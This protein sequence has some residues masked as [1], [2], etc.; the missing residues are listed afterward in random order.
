MP[1]WKD[2]TGSEGVKASRIRIGM[3]RLSIHHYVGCGDEWFASCGYLFSR[4]SLKGQDLVSLKSQALNKLEN[5]IKE[6]SDDINKQT[7]YDGGCTCP[8]GT[9]GG[10][11][12]SE[13]CP[14]HCRFVKTIAE[15]SDNR[16]R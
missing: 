16:R 13:N 9:E 6:A 10:F 12:I 1:E 15:C 3:F 4:L 11:M 5:I 8:G 2:E 14:A 7:V